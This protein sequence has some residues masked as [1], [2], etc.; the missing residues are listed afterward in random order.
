MKFVASAA[1]ILSLFYSSSSSETPAEWGCCEV[2]DVDVLLLLFCRSHTMRA[3]AIVGSDE[4]S[5]QLQVPLLF[6]SCDFSFSDFKDHF[7]AHTGG[8]CQS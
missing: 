2:V 8:I 1:R 4:G 6:E 5:L 3:W 7:R